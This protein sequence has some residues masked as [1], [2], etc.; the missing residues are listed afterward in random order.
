MILS[1]CKSDHDKTLSISSRLPIFIKII[2]RIIIWL[3]IFIPLSPS[4]LNIYASDTP[5]HCTVFNWHCS[6]RIFLTTLFKTLS[7]C[8]TS[9]LSTH[10]CCCVCVCVYIAFI[11]I[12]IFYFLILSHTFSPIS[13]LPQENINSMR[14]EI[15]VILLTYLQSLIYST[16]DIIDC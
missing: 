8:S 14:V 3:G 13:S 1:K 6:V 12:S 9:K 15:F 10:T 16:W 4:A 7:S 2:S 11:T 5:L